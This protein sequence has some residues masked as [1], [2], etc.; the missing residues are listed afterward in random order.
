MAYQVIFKKRA[1]KELQSLSKPIQLLI[2]GAIQKLAIDPHPPTSRKLVNRPG[3]RVRIG[4]YRII[5]TVH[6]E[7][8][9]INVIHV[10]HRR[11]IY[12]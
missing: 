3:Y 12:L 5:Y 10:G 6:N 4:D 8:L 2:S 1:Q 9:T 7:I 11:E